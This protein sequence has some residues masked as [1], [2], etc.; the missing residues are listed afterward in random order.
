MASCGSA[1]RRSALRRTGKRS[2]SDWD[3]TLDLVS[4]DHKCFDREQKAANRD[5]FRGIPNGLPG[6]ELRVPALLGQVAAGRLGWPELALLTAEMPARIFDLWPRKGAIAVGADA[7]L[8][9][10]DP[11]GVT[12]L[13]ASHMAT[14]YS[15][16]AGLRARGRVT[17][18]WLRGA[19]VVVDGRF[20]GQRG[21]GAWLGPDATVIS[22]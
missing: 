7:D 8:V 11:D 6:I 21:S 17:Q 15:P 14:D 1:R 10:V 12:D 22:A 9:L 19:Q 20:M 3:A 4:T 13:G 2:G 18:T 16:F 5:D